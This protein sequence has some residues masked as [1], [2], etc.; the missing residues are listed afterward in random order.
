LDDLQQGRQFCRLVELD[1]R[2][3]HV[4]FGLDGVGSFALRGRRRERDR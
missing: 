2:C 3:H 1:A 4:D